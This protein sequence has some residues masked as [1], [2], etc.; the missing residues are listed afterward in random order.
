MSR[1]FESDIIPMARTFGQSILTAITL[2]CLFN[3][4]RYHIAH[5]GLALAPWDV[6]AGGH[7]RSDAEEQRRHET[8]EKGRT[9]MGPQ[10]ERTEDEKKMSR[11]LE[12]VAL[13]VAREEG[14]PSVQAGELIL[15]KYGSSVSLLK[16]HVYN[17]CDRVHTS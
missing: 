13:E 15:S 9:L 7:L 8:G 2:M 6:L 17:S 14:P 5:I 3:S 11:A 10:W 16:C 12:K 1:S 4:R